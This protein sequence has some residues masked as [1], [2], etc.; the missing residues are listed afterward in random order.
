[1]HKL[2]P[3]ED[4]F[5]RDDLAM[6]CVDFKFFYLAHARES[7]IWNNIFF[8]AKANAC[9]RSLLINERKFLIV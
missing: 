7:A 4:C 1:M 5:S 8:V 9:L 6:N 2:K 3:N